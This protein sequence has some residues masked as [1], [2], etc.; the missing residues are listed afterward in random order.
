MVCSEVSKIKLYIVY[1]FA[2]VCLLLN[3]QY[4]Y[5]TRAHTMLE[6]SHIEITHNMCV[7]VSLALCDMCVFQLDFEF[8]VHTQ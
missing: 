1:I 7:C 5:N 2:V 4:I 3:I 6:C 8:L